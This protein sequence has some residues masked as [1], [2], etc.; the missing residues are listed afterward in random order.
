MAAPDIVALV[1]LG[2]E[3]VF[4]LTVSIQ[5]DATVK[6]NPV[7]TPAA[8]GGSASVAWGEEFTG[9]VIAF[10]DTSEDKDGEQSVEA[11]GNTV[12]RRKRTFLVKGAD[13]TAVPNEETDVVE[14][15]ESWNVF[16]VER[17]PG[18]ALYILYAR[19]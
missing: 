15:G 1:A 12:K 18:D 2:V 9:K 4:A 11:R 14:A 10:D 5:V 7:S 8:D 19:R 3:N 6:L 17:V 16:K 13:L